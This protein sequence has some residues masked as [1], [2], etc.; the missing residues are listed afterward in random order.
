MDKENYKGIK[1]VQYK[2]LIIKRGSNRENERQTIRY[3]ENKKQNDST[4]FSLISNYFK[5]QWIEPA[6]Q[7]AQASKM[8]LKKIYDPPTYMLSITDSL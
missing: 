1:I 3:R 7:K 8:G 2:K 4:K 5:Y 6:N